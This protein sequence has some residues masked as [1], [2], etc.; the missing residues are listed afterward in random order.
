VRLDHVTLSKVIC[1][2][3]HCSE[4]KVTYQFA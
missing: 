2:E 4:I 1:F 3:K